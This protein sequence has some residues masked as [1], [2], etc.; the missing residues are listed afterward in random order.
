MFEVNT[1]WTTAG[2]TLA[3]LLTDSTKSVKWRFFFFVAYQSTPTGTLELA[4]FSRFE[5]RPLIISQHSGPQKVVEFSM[6]FLVATTPEG[7]SGSFFTLY[8]QHSLSSH[9]DGTCLPVVLGEPV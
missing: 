6:S 8:I 9:L 2:A 4:L 5:T 3:K 7:M 1:S